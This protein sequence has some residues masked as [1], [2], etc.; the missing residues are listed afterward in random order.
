[1]RLL[2]AKSMEEYTMLPSPSAILSVHELIKLPARLALNY[3]RIPYKTEW[4]EYPDL[5]PKFKAL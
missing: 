2:V 3:K 4:V 1:M 5:E